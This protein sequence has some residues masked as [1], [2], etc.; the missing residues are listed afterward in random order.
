MTTK[1]KQQLTITEPL[2]NS[3]IQ[4]ATPMTLIEKAMS[5]PNFDLDKLER[6]MKMQTE[7]DLRQARKDFFEAL[8]RFQ[9]ECPTIDKN[10]KADFGAGKTKY[11]F[12][13]L[14]QI[15]SQIKEPLKNCGLTYRF[16]IK[17][18]EG[19]TEV[20]CVITHVGGHSETTTMVAGSDSSGSKNA[21]QAKGSTMTYLQRYTL[22]GSLGITTAGADND[23]KTSEPKSKL[24]DEVLHS[25]LVCE[26]T[27]QLTTLWNNSHELQKD[28]SFIN[29]MSKRRKEV[30]K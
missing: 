5:D 10:G 17:D 18:L 26:T 12:A 22:I 8:S 13:T 6:L 14:D 7:W 1:P 15:I 11:S 21:I 9:Y 23:G 30:T 27:E 4:T 25:I 20:T 24:S 16:N 19:T 29:A 3:F 2:E 28:Q